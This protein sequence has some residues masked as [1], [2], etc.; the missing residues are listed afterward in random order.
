MTGT[1][2][3]AGM[4]DAHA[5]HGSAAPPARPGSATASFTAEAWERAAPVRD[6]IDALPLVR[7][8]GDGSL[9]RDRFDYYMAQDALYL[10]EYGRALAGVAA[11][12]DEPDEFV[13]WCDAAREAVV[14]ER[15]L[16]AAHVDLTAGADASPTCRAYTDFL[17]ARCALVS[18]GVA[19]AA[20]LPCFWIYQDV[21]AGMIARAG[22]LGAHP[23]G[24]WIATYADPG[25][26]RSTDRVR[27]IADRLARAAGDGERERM[28]ASFA[29]ACRHEWMFWDAAWRMERSPV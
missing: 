14:V 2:D 20:V 13:F 11:L 9:T 6:A 12:S 1:T 5:A 24:D 17:R 10:A 23:Y 4:R 3:T 16:H 28:H 27:S 22:D 29:T 18:Y 26:E 19:V 8:L 25:F 15:A 7:G 21:G